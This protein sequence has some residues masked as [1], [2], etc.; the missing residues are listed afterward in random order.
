LSSAH[1]SRIT[2]ITVIAVASI[3]L[4]LVSY[5][6]SANISNRAIELSAE[7]VRSNAEIEA[8]DISQLLVNKIE[9]I[10]DN[11]EIMASAQSVQSQ[12]LD[13][14]KSLFDAAQ[15]STRELTESYFW[16][17]RNG[18]LV[19]ADA[20]SNATIYEQYRGGDRTQRSYF[21]EPRDT[22]QAHISSV[23]ESVDGVPRLYIAYPILAHNSSTAD[24]DA[25]FKGVVVAASD[26]G[27]FGEFLNSQISTKFQHSIGLTDREGTVLYS[28]TSE[29]IGKDVFGPVTQGILPDEIKS[30]FN[31]IVRDA[32]AGH[33]GSGDFAY[34]GNVSTI[35]YQPVSVRGTDFGVLYV[36]APHQLAIETT[37]LIEE[38]RTIS[39]V[40]I[41]AIATV[42]A[43]IAFVVLTWNS[44]LKRT[45]SRRTEELAKSNESLQE[46]VKQL[47]SHDAMQR[48]F[49]NVAAHELRTPVQPLLGISELIRDSIGHNDKA[50]ISREEVEIL[51]RNA[52]RLERLASTLLDVSRIESN[53]LKLNLEVINMNDKITNV[54]EDIRSFIDAAQQ[55]IDIIFETKT[56]N[57]QPVM[58]RADKTRLFEVLSNL[59]RNAIKF[60]KKGMIAVTLEEREG[61]A[62]VRVKDTGS[63]IDAAILPRLFEKFATNSDQ[64]TGLGLY[65][66]KGII[67]AHNGRIWAEN[68]P[69][70]KG[71]TFTFT[72]PTITESI[73]AKI[74]SS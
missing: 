17:D 40:T 16:V 13:R 26:L 29:I 66:S 25:E 6:Y 54:I 18:K 45:V 7:D 41:G 48:E 9:G 52:M 44:Q 20:F 12:E 8:H 53:S 23:I 39:L 71:A 47:K 73:P 69:D 68:N 11:L 57:G 35:A 50:E 72:L 32:L 27:Q 24:N 46:A 36:I 2:F 3:A 31:S 30:T 14:A 34:Q 28:E 42:S 22:A 56:P 51:E 65:L 37:S 64:G 55:D 5:Q 59:L 33:T 63:G 67:E 60:T 38:Q 62:I 10:M 43:G 70:G 74:K 61:H 21:I 4:S 49:I 15:S 58:I 1:A 19:W